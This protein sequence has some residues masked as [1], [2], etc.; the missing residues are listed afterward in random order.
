MKARPIFAAGA[1]LKNTFCF[2]RDDYAFLS[3]H[4]GDMENYE[5]LNSYEKSVEYFQ[6]L[7]RIKPVAIAYDLHPDYLASRFALNKAEEDGLP[8]VGIQH[9]HAH[10]A[11]C[12]AEN[13]LP[14]DSQVIGIALDGTGYGDDEQIWGGEFLLAGY[15]AYQRAAHLAYTPLPGGD[16]A[17]RKPARIALAYLW[18][19]GIEWEKYLPPV[20]V[21]CVEDRNIIRTQL[22]KGIN[23]PFTS[24]MGRLFDA[25]AAIIGMRQEINYEAQAAI[26]LEA[27][28]DLEEKGKYSFDFSHPGDNSSTGETQIEINPIINSVV[29]DFLDH[30]SPAIIAARFH[31]TVAGIVYETSIMLRE[32]TGLQDVVFSGGVWQN[33]HLLKMTLALFAGTDFRVFIHRLSPPNDGGLALGQAVIADQIISAS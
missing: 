33:H 27:I 13:K 9:H 30:V 2:T 12:M 14:T 25:V 28:L 3:H 7:Y 24:S 6:S 16:V 21:F 18:N 11:A 29:H 4:I 17:I 10:I 32:R 19:A 23:A 31:N 5:T 15:R 22:E 26:E 20:N 1:E 8:V